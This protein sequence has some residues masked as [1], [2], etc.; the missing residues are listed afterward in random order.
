MKKQCTG[1]LL[2][3]G[4]NRRLPGTKKAFLE[5]GGKRIIDH[6]LAI[7]EELFDET[8]IVTNDPVDFL[9]WDHRIVS[10]I[11]PTRCSLAG[12]HAGLFHARTPY[13]FVSACDTPF[14]NAG[15]VRHLAHAIHPPLQVVIP[16]TEMGLEALCAVYAKSCIA[17]I[18]R[19]LEQ[20]RYAIRAF[21]KPGRTRKIGEPELRRHDPALHSFFNINTPEDLALAEKMAAA[22]TPRP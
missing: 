11:S 17:P 21:F 15:L 7:F 12:I 8:I 6:I 19:N 18:E 22:R 2:A 3:G 13:I 4:K 10:D 5:V 1:V 14:L 9:E 20:G 16:R